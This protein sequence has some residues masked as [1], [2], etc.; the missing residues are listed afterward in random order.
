MTRFKLALVLA[1]TTAAL[2]WSLPAFGRAETATTT[3]TVTAGKPSQFHFELSTST[4]KVGKVVF[5]VVNKGTIA[6]N[7]KIDGKAT[8]LIHPGK[9]ARLTVVFKKAGIYPYLCTVPGHAASGMKGVLT[10]TK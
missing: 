2:A 8:P 4:V 3:V 1:T 5:D 7:F 10:V 6:H 9:S